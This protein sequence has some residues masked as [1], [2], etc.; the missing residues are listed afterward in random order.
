VAC[1]TVFRLIKNTLQTKIKHII[2]K[3]FVGNNKIHMRRQ[4]KPMDHEYAKLSWRKS[5]E[6][7][8]NEKNQ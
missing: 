2:K 1:L 8:G 6:Y 4:A 7:V 3:Y 5:T